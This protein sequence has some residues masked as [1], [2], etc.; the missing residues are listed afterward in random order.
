MFE[1]LPS[2][3]G[4]KP[5][6]HTGG[7][8]RFHLPL[9]YDL[10]ASKKPRLMVTQGVGDGQAFFTF[11]QAVREK[12]I[13]CQCVAVRRERA[14]E[15]ESD[16]VAWLKGKDYGEEFYG[17]LVRFQSDSDGVREV[18]DQSVDLLLLDDCDS[19]AGIR[20]DLSI[21]ESK[22]AQNALVLCHGVALER[23]DDPRAAWV[24]WS[25]SRPTAE[26][27]DGIGLGITLP[28]ETGGTRE[29]L[30][31]QLFEG[32]EAIAALVE[33]YRLAVARIEAEVRADEAVRAQAALE[34]RQ[35][36]IDS[37]LADRWKVQEIMDY[38]A[39][40]IAEHERKFEALSGIGRRR[41][42]SSMANRSS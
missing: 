19:G 18:A 23:V 21:W 7:P 6:F 33:T 5:K 32:K 15:T 13:E 14:G 25:A 35:V 38:Q 34:A 22:L 42:S 41:N 11:C 31:Q 36:W 30:F 27:P 40:A 3:L 26:F 9:L 10:V 12:N 2:L 29:G 20:A 37:L 16:D 39:R 1:K 4:F 17:D 8:T 28:S 24:E